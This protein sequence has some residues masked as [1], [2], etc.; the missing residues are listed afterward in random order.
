[1][2]A[3]TQKS[4]DTYH[5]YYPIYQ[6]EVIICHIYL[7]LTLSLIK[8]RV[9][10]NHDQSLPAHFDEANARA[11]IPLSEL[12]V[13]DIHDWIETKKTYLKDVETDIRDAKR[14]VTLA[15]GPKKRNQEPAGS[16]SSNDNDDE[17][18]VEG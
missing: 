3:T 16:I 7:H 15:K 12:D 11:S 18:A 13:D 8:V 1:M 5:K 17:S 2:T 14:R 10:R 9:L 4:N 6:L